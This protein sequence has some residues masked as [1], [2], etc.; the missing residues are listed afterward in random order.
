MSSDGSL[1]SRCSNNLRMLFVAVAVIACATD[2]IAAENASDTLAEARRLFLVGKYAE[3][4]ESFTSHEQD[5]NLEAAVGIARC[6]LALG[7][8]DEAEAAL[9]AA[10]TAA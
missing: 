3:A 5:R 8:T 4:E 9:K 1:N 6:K 2:S 7:K 10:V